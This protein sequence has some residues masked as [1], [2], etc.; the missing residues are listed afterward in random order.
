M[1]IHQKTRL[2][3]STKA[4]QPPFFRPQVFLVLCIDIPLLVTRK[5]KPAAIDALHKMYFC[6]DVKILITHISFL[7][8]L[9]NV[10]LPLTCI[11]CVCFAVWSLS[12]FSV[13]HPGVAIGFL[14][15]LLSLP[16]ALLFLGP[17]V[18]SLPAFLFYPSVG[19]K[20]N[21]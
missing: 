14:D 7:F 1:A 19:T 9:V 21:W 11:E 18:L 17:L 4:L 20:N 16:G 15:V 5:L 13:S 6:C 10:S 2:P 12:W 8:Y 3:N